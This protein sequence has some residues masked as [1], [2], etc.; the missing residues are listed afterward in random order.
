MVRIWD[1][2]RSFDAESLQQLRGRSDRQP[3]DFTLL[4]QLAERSAQLGSADRARQ[5]FAQA[6]DVAPDEATFAAATDRVE[7]ILARAPEGQ[8]PAQE[9]ATHSPR[10]SAAAVA[11]LTAV[12]S[13]LDAN[14]TDAAINAFQELLQTDG[15][16][17][18]L[19]F[20]RTYFSRARWNV[21]WFGSRIDPQIN[22]EAWRA[23]ADADGAITIPVRALSFPYRNR[24]PKDLP[25]DSRLTARGPDAAPFGMIARATFPTGTGKGKWRFTAKGDGSL[26]VLVDGKVV[27]EKWS[28]GGAF[29][30]SGEYEPG[31]AAEMQIVV[32]YSAPGAVQDFQL[33][34]EPA[35]GL[36]PRPG[37]AT[38]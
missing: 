32:E 24:P 25:L 37:V 14:E 5:I 7:Q 1:A 17:P 30:E 12:H 34:I 16:E 9:P 8:L 28:N 18:A 26:R 19:P 11:L 38:P 13:H 36:A 35:R 4:R 33:T 2:T 3:R 29:E 6:R 15:N 27:I 20:A 10:L 31:A 22:V 21:T 23:Q